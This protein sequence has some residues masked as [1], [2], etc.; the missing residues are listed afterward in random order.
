M[1]MTVS[2]GIVQIG[3]RQQQTTIV[4]SP[5]CVIRILVEPC[6]RVEPSKEHRRGRGE[7]DDRH[8][9]FCA[10]TQPYTHTFLHCF[11]LQ[12][13]RL[14]SCKAVRLGGG[15]GSDSRAKIGV[16]FFAA[17]QPRPRATVLSR[18]TPATGHEQQC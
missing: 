9:S 18:C 5:A 4:S 10:E 8:L 11:G 15:E 13:A 16:Q 12:G 2:T 6:R 17:G 7:V 3:S 1:G 14:E